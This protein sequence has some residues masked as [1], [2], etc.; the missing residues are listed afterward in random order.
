[1]YVLMI[2][3]DKWAKEGLTSVVYG[4]WLANGILFLFGMYFMRQA[5][6][7]S[8]LFE[9]DVYKMYLQQLSAKIGRWH[10]VSLLQKKV[11]KLLKITKFF[12]ILH[13]FLL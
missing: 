1:M 3:G 2:N 12:V 9:A 4:A 8:R 11:N 10:W 5:Q 13:L 6:N 7:D